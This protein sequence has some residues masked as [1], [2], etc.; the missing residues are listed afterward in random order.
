[1]HG[2]RDVPPVISNGIADARR[3]IATLK[4]QAARVGRAG[5]GYSGDESPDG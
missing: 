3:E 4:R 2:E 1:M 5:G